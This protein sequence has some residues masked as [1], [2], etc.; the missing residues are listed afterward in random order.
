VHMSSR[1]QVAPFLAMDVLREANRLEADGRRIY[2]LETGQPGAKAPA[3][4]RAAAKASLDNDL[5]GYTEALG[6]P[7]LKKAIAARY[8]RQYGLEIDPQ[9]VVITTGSSAG[10]VL[11][12]LTLFEA[13]QGLAM[14]A[15]GYPAYRNTA[16]ALN[17]VPQ[18]IPAGDPQNFLLEPQ[19]LA[20]LEHTHGLLLA[21]PG[22]PTGTVLPRPVLAGLAAL[23]R[24]KGW[25]L[26]SDEIYHG[27]TYGAETV[28]AL[29]VEP[30]A[31]VINS[32][33]KYF[34]MTGWRI[35][36]MILP[37]RIVR[38]VE[39]LAQNLYI[40]PPTIS[41][42][43][44]LAALTADDELQTHV[45][46]YRRNRDRLLEALNAGGLNKTAPA[47]GAFYLYTDISRLGP[48]AAVIAK[49]LLQETG[50]AVTPGMDF[51]PQDGG[52]WLRLSYA[53]AEAEVAEAAGILT[54]WLK[55][56]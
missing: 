52:H 22:N 29:S 39:R 2:H 34:A 30:D 26:I 46:A 12:F 20:K 44:A 27:L 8:A 18:Q 24:E 5:L 6:R 31:I 38:T 32:F 1:A 14:A 36:W 43:A 47:D 56:G 51:D 55:R 53:G 10:F 21:S 17:L 23:C 35:G 33:S 7:A 4:A 42:V 50:I 48:D 37:E 9:R 3:A 41:Q 13:G 54:A 49:R 28:T 16:I 25:P 15:P 45:A 19:Q 40:S 11:A